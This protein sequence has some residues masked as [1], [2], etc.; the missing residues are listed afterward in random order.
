MVAIV[1]EV[2]VEASEVPGR[3]HVLFTLPPEKE[4]GILRPVQAY[5]LSEG[6][7]EA[8]LSGLRRVL[9]KGA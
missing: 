1:D 5:S 6:S 3:V 9:G 7:A 2:G 8:L 4:N